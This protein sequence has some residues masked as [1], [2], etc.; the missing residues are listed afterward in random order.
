MLQK[1][2]FFEKLYQDPFDVVE[3]F[4]I[5]ISLA[6]IVRSWQYKHNYIDTYLHTYVLT[7]PQPHKINYKYIFT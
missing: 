1:V 6:W 5:K 3:C 4:I 2:K 7:F